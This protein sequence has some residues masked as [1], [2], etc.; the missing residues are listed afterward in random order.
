M[1]TRNFL[2]EYDIVKKLKFWFL[3]TPIIVCLLLR[4][5]GL[6]F[7]FRVFCGQVLNR[8]ILNKGKGAFA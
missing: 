7:C 2:L 1:L 8:M 3:S 5:A 6:F 4:G